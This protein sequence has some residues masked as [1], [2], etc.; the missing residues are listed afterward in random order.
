[1]AED[2][3]QENPAELTTPDRKDVRASPESSFTESAIQN[4]KGISIIIKYDVI[5][6]LK[7]SRMIILMV[8]FV[9]TILSGAY[10][11]AGIAANYAELDPPEFLV[12]TYI[13]NSDDDSNPND[14]LVITTD[15]AGRP[16]DNVVISIYNFNGTKLDSGNTDISGRTIF[17][18]IDPQS[19]LNCRKGDFEISFR[20][21]II[22]RMQINQLLG[23]LDVY[24]QAQAVDLDRDNVPDDV[25]ILVLN[26]TLE[27][28][29]GVEIAKKGGDVDQAETNMYGV[30]RDY[31]LLIDRYEYSIRLNGQ[32]ITEEVEVVSDDMELQR[33]L[34]LQGP[35]EV[36]M[37]IA[38]L[39]MAMIIPIIAIG[40]S[41]DSI[42]REKISRSI[43]FLLCR[44]IGKRSIAV[45]KFLG[46]LIALAIPLTLVSLVGVAIISAVT[47]EV[48]TGSFVAGFIIASI[49]FMAIFILLQQIFSTL[50]KT[51][52]N[53]ILAGISLWLF[54]YIFWSLIVIAI[55]YAL[56]NQLYSQDFIEFSNKLT[57][58]SPTG[59]YSLIINEIAPT[60]GGTPA[61]ITSWAPYLSY[62]IWFGVLFFLAIELFRKKPYL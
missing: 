51:T 46:S 29:Q 2:D 6:H 45:G 9:L 13:V 44:P 24:I 52:G 26:R 3:K 48:P 38:G 37:Q 11:F 22:S 7:S 17:N 25:A 56:G 23:E 33:L 60:G 35:D 31:N 58:L 18:D 61:G 55:N 49:M 42:S 41:F 10:L 36:L 1:M 59:S 14:A 16:V 43:V 34:D 5:S 47:S 4:I 54:F 15:I 8:I 27:P 20:T 30:S 57:L 19:Y 21:I 28:L 40:I 50:A 53:A 12:W 62:A 32:V 39:F